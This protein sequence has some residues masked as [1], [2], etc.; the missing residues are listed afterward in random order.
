MKLYSGESSPYLPTFSDGMPCDFQPLMDFMES[1]AETLRAKLHSHPLGIPV[2][3]TFLNIHPTPLR[4]GEGDLLTC[5]VR[6]QRHGTYP[7][8]FSLNSR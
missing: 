4:S 1:L 6:F 2:V 7:K 3:Q 8:N 5:R